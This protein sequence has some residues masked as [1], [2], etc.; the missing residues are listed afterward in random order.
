MTVSRRKIQTTDVTDLHGSE[1]GDSGFRRTFV[2]KIS[3]VHVV[4]AIRP[5]LGRTPNKNLIRVHS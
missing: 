2:V 3:G 4:A 1:R 5:D